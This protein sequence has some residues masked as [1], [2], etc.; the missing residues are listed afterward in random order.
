MSILSSSPALNQPWSHLVSLTCVSPD[1]ARRCFDELQ[2][3]A[4]EFLHA[5]QQNVLVVTSQ[6]SHCCQQF[7]MLPSRVQLSVLNLIATKLPSFQQSVL[8]RF[9]ESRLRDTQFFAPVKLALQQIHSCI[10]SA[11][12]EFDSKAQDR[13]V[14]EFDRMV[15]RNV[16]AMLPDSAQLPVTPHSDYTASLLTAPSLFLSTSSNTT[17]TSV[18]KRSIKDVYSAEF[19]DELLSKRIKPATELKNSPLVTHASAE[20]P[21]MVVVEDQLPPKKSIDWNPIARAFREDIIRVRQFF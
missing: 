8:L 5:L 6:R 9:T 2:H 15:V 13:K 7:D 12:G 14:Y 17:S 3:R 1:Q 16:F 18:W 11:S 21:T 10:C 19:L 20:V 4:D